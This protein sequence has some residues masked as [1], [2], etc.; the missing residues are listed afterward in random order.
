MTD[1][2][3]APSE[4]SSPGILLLAEL[5]LSDDNAVSVDNG[6]PTITLSTNGVV[7]QVLSDS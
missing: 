3:G 4:D 7:Q 6:H 5:I 1:Q 2:L